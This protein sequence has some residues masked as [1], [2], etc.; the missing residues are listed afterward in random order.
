MSFQFT[1]VIAYVVGC[2]SQDVL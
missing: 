2:G 1:K